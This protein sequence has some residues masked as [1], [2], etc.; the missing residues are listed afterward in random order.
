MYSVDSNVASS[1][2]IL[3]MIGTAHTTARV[4]MPRPRLLETHDAAEPCPLQACQQCHVLQFTAMEPLVTCIDW[5][6]MEFAPS[7][8]TC[9]PCSNFTVIE[10][11]AVVWRSLTRPTTPL[12]FVSR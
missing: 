7:P 4:G 11:I 2:E 3:L 1:A 12:P 9:A 10:I 8:L 5:V 6:M